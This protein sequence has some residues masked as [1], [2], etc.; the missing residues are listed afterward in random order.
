MGFLV[1]K[2][3]FSAGRL[4]MFRKNNELF[5]LMDK[6]LRHWHCRESLREWVKKRYACA[7]FNI[8]RS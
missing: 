5:Y 8:R 1:A 2:M 3:T 6:G 4:E 7:L